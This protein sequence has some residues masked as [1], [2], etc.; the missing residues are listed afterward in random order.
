MRQ[1]CIPILSCLPAEYVGIQ[2]AGHLQICVNVCGV[3][4]VFE[5]YSYRAGC[6]AVV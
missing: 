1:H 4:Y 6:Y 3:R 5:Q 2:L